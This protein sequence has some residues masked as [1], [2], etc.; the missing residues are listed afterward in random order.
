[1]ERVSKL[2]QELKENR[3]HGTREYPYSQYFIYNPKGKFHIP[4]HWHDEVE[5]I[6][7]K[8]GKLTIYIGEEKI[9][10]NQGEVF[11]V[12]TGDLH[13]MESD[14]I[15]VE[16]YTLLFPLTFLS[17]KMDSALE[18]EFFLPLRQKKLLMPVRI[19]DVETEKIQISIVAEQK[20]IELAAK[21]AERKEKE[22]LE[23]MVKPAEA[24]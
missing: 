3:P 17:F 20:N 24:Q 5:I 4:V 12:N 7:I 6:Y 16:Y 13:F 14:D 8:K 2:Y 18:K 21:K 19:K 10:A 23:T 9:L 1:M 15:N 11:F 22:L